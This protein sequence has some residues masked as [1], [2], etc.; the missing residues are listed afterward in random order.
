MP[1]RDQRLRLAA[2]AVL[3]IMLL[4][5]CGAP[6]S[7]PAHAGTVTSTA[8]ATSTATSSTAPLTFR[9]VRFSSGRPGIAPF[10]RQVNDSSKAQQF[11]QYVMGMAPAP[12]Y[13]SCPQ[14]T[15]GGYLI[16][17]TRG[18][19]IVLQALMTAGGCPYLALSP[20]NGCRY[21]DQAF[22]QYLAQVLGVTSDDLWVRDN[23]APPGGPV[24]PVDP[25]P[26]YLWGS[27]S[28]CGPNR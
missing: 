8:T 16:N 17:F 5:G 1:H 14:Y 25:P 28:V 24:A 4:A 23:T 12:V 13:V 21:R 20:P 18:D 2:L 27:T 19:A 10:D 22:T 7:K 11:Y 15:G 3:S 9:I 6:S 26:P